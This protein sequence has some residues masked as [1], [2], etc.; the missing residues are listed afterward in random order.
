M[1]LVNGKRQTAWFG[2]D[3]EAEGTFAGVV[4]NRPMD[5]ILTYR[6]PQRLREVVC[7]GQRVRVPLGRGNQPTVGYCVR[8]DAALPDGVESGRVKDVLEVL[9]DPPLIDA[10]MLELTRW[11][12]GYYACSWG[13]ALD[14]VVPAG[15]KKQAGTRVGTF[16]T[17]P[18]EVR[19]VRASLDLPTKQAEAL[20]IL[21]RSDEPLTIADLCRMAKC[22]PGLI[23]A[24]RQRGY[25]HTVKRRVRPGP[26]PPRA[27]EPEADAGRIRPAL[28]AEQTAVLDR[29]AP[30]LEEDAFATFLIHGVTGSGKTEVYLSA[31]ERVVARGREAIVLV[32]EI[33]LTPQTIRRFRSRFPRVAVL[34]SHLSDAERHRHWQ[35]IASGEVQVVVGALGGLR[36][37]ATARPDRHRRGAREHVQARDHPTLPR[38][39]RRRE[40]GAT[41]A[42]ADPARLGHSG[43]GDLAERRVGPLRPAADARARR[44][45][46]MPAVELID[47]RHERPAL[48]GLSESLRQA[49]TAALDAGGQVILLLNRRGFHTFVICPNPQCGQVLKCHHCDVALTYHK[50][51]RLLICHTCDAERPPARV[52]PLPCPP[53]PLWRDRDRAA[54]ARDRD[55]VSVPRRAADGLGHDAD[56]GQPRAGPL[57]LPGGRGADPAGHADDRQGA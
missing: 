3:P 1:S 28:T 39:R 24:L 16:L 37:D 20:T 53:P 57:G 7:P 35:S 18:E 26:A 34:H 2:G 8:V 50:S 27:D 5:L 4:F 10:V 44:R 38:A 11:M 13:Q 45:R 9:D 43:V 41:G 56:A 19:Q 40:A 25:I 42:V 49:M 48:G 52:P 55:G 17:V 46:P 21:C 31:I 51:R 23:A 29:L 47:L 22:A 15:V 6:I 32:P 14:A 30:A 33:S 36:A 54:R 12:A